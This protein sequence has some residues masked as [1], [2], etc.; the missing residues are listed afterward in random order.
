MVELGV[1]SLQQSGNATRSSSIMAVVAGD[2]RTCTRT[3]T[4]TVTHS[5]CSG[6]AIVGLHGRIRIIVVAIQRSRS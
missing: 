4:G 5:G 2:T 3:C 6:G 1:G